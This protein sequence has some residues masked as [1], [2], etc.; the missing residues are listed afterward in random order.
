MWK[1]CFFSHPSTRRDLRQGLLEVLGA[2]SQSVE[3][4]TGGRSNILDDILLECIGYTGL[5][6]LRLSIQQDSDPHLNMTAGFDY[7]DFR[8]W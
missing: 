5:A 7:H 4:L 1:Y 2:Y 6:L 3:M 8:Q